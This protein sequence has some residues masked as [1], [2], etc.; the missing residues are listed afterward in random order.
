MKLI[1]AKYENWKI[2]PLGKIKK[3]KRIWLYIE[4]ENND[5]KESKS[6]LSSLIWIIK[7]DYSDD[8]KKYLTDKY[9]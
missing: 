9:S 4:E 8:Y 1:P 5:R 3:P 2:I 6:D 7:K